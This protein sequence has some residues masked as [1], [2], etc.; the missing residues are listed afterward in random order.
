MRHYIE[1]KIITDQHPITITLIGCGGTGSHVLNNLARINHALIAIGRKG[2]SV[3]V[4]DP[5]VVS[6]SNIGRQVYYQNDIGR[7]KS[8]VC[9]ERVNR[10]F[11]LHWVSLPRKFDSDIQSHGASN[12]IISCVDTGKTRMSI[13]NI[14]KT[15]H[16]STYQ[17]HKLS[18][19]W[20]DF[21]NTKNTGQIILGTLRDINQPES[22]FKTVPKLQTVVEKYGNMIKF[23]DKEEQGPSCSTMEALNKQDLFINSQLAILG[24]NLL[25]NFL[26]NYYTEISQIFFNGSTYL[27]ASNYQQ[28]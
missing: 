8:D 13:A 6:E 25:W 10:A 2:I 21:G 14:L 15:S 26:K 3:Q 22:Q 20:L 11:G 23:D 7:S 18:C 28:L 5:D 1:N 16:S 24:S 19:Y 9:V 4:C 17:P 12:I 27:T